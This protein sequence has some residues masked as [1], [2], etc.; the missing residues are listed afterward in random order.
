MI[1]NE[2]YPTEEKCRIR[3]VSSSK[4]DRRLAPVAVIFATLVSLVGVAALEWSTVA[5]LLLYWGEIGVVIRW[6]GVR[7][8]FGHRPLDYQTDKLLGRSAD[9][10]PPE[11]VQPWILHAGHVTRLCG[12]GG[13]RSL[14]SFCLWW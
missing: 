2:I 4:R 11:G 12:R 1:Q 5:L 8:L 14:S 7:A 3:M 9:R 13:C 10:S 6:A